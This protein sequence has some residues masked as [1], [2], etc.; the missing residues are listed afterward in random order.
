MTEA[1]LGHGGDSCLV[2]FLPLYDWSRDS[3][4]SV[5]PSESLV[6]K[7]G[8]GL[9]VVGQVLEAISPHHQELITHG[10]GIPRSTESS[11]VTAWA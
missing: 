6:G 8:G 10:V 3:D 11:C 5:G 9:P 7:A 2:W 1:A 4:L